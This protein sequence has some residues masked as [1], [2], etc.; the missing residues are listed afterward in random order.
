MYDEARPILHQVNSL[1]IDGKGNVQDYLFDLSTSFYTHRSIMLPT[2]SPRIISIPINLIFS[3]DHFHT[4]GSNNGSSELQIFRTFS[5]AIQSMPALH[6]RKLN[7]LI[8]QARQTY[9][10]D[11]VPLLRAFFTLPPVHF[12]NVTIEVSTPPTSSEED[13]LASIATDLTAALH[14]PPS[15]INHVVSAFAAFKKAKLRVQQAMNKGE[16][17]CYTI[18]PE[19][20]QLRSFILDDVLRASV[21]YYTPLWNVDRELYAEDE[22]IEARA[23]EEHDLALMFGDVLIGSEWRE[24]EVA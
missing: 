9:I 22:D 15:P 7:I 19:L 24:I 2:T 14:E 6:F 23:W 21:E 18:H 3:F 17:C 13:I 10:A 1:Y 11:Y 20:E 8:R 5:A 12:G 16:A 4:T